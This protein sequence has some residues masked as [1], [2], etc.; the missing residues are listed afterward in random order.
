MDER[1]GGGDK[2]LPDFYV[3]SQPFFVDICEYGLTDAHSVHILC[4]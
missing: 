4:I 1:G 2:S 3:V